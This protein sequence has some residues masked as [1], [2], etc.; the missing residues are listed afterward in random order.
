MKVALKRSLLII[1]IFLYAASVTRDASSFPSGGTW[2]PIF[3]RR[4]DGDW[5]DSWGFDRNFYGGEQGYMPNLA[6]E[7]LGANRELAY[8]IGT[9]FKTD[10]PS[11]TQRAV[12]ILKYIQRWTDYGYDEDNV[13][14]GGIAQE[15]WA[16]NADETAHKLDTATNTVAIGDCEDMAFFGATLYTAAGFDAALIDAPSH[17]ALLVWL[18]DY[19][20]ANYYWDI[21]NDDRGKGWIWVEATG[22]RNSLGWT[23]P[24][25]ADGEWNAYPLGLMISSVDYA[26][27]KPQEKDDVT[28]TASITSARTALAQIFLEYSIQG[29]AYSTVTMTAAG[30]T[31]RATIPKQSEGTSVEFYIS[32]ID[33]EGNSKESDKHSYTVGQGF[34]IPGFPWES[35]IIGLVIGTALIALLRRRK[36]DALTVKSPTYVRSS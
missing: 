29:V 32:A 30:S 14:M 12:E 23:P 20:N 3:T 11:K 9:T 35:I 31:Y 34:D 24:D 5:Y 6:Y 19:S 7:T 2:P 33:D 25:F 17:V 8:S 27:R 16:W 13:L 10:Y 36:S 4:I 1:I 22:E 21:P 18:P 26:P 28:V 15:E